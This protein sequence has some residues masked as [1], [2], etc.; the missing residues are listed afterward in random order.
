MK[1]IEIGKGDAMKTS[2]ANN[3]DARAG[4]S[5]KTAT[6]DLSQL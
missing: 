6:K 2:D 1:A 3:K 5:G 4:E